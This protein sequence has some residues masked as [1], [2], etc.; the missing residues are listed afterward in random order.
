MKNL[1][2]FFSTICLLLITSVSF[3]QSGIANVDVKTLSDDAVS[4]STLAF[5]IDRTA[6]ADITNYILDNANHPFEALAYANEVEVDLQIAV[7]KNGEIIDVQVLKATDNAFGKEIKN[8]VSE[9]PAVNPITVNG[10][11][12]TQSIQ[13]P[14]K[15][16]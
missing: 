4:T 3:A 10:L 2:L 13:L 5:D 6:I 1:K 11:A 9:M 16:K 7:N 14:L 12:T 8:L 15:F